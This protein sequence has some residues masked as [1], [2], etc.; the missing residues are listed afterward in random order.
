MNISPLGLPCVMVP[1][2]AL[3]LLVIRASAGIPG[4]SLGFLLL[5]T[6][7]A[8]SGLCPCA[9]ALLC[10]EINM[11]WATRFTFFLLGRPGCSRASRTLVPPGCT[12]TCLADSAG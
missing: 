12:W 10:Y 4:H 11:H 5:Q 1:I 8:Q 6:L 2:S 7:A 9:P 3:L